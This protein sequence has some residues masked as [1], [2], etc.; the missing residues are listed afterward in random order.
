MML[1]FGIGFALGATAAIGAVAGVIA[2]AMRSA[3][4]QEG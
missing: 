2:L 1:A 3:D 4:D